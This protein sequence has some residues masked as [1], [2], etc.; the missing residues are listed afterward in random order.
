MGEV[1]R[2]E[3]SKCTLAGG[4]IL[5]LNSNLDNSLMYRVVL[6]FVHHYCKVFLMYLFFRS[7]LAVTESATESK[8]YDEECQNL[9]INLRNYFNTAATILSMYCYEKTVITITT[10]LKPII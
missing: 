6:S 10:Y 5:H 2:L 3:Y 1:S 4:K 9:F 7:F 8:F